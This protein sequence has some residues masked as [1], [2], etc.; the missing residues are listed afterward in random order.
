MTVASTINQTVYE[1]I[2]LLTKNIY[3]NES[4][5]GSFLTALQHNMNIGYL[6]PLN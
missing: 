5:K 1:Y 3:N 2:N 4:V 6:V